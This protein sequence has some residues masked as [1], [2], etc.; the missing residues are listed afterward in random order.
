[1]IVAQDVVDDSGRILLTAGKKL[2]AEMI[3][4]L[5]KYSL[6][7]V[8]IED[9]GV[10]LDEEI[11]RTGSLVNK[12]VRSKLLDCVSEAFFAGSSFPEVFMQLEEQVRQIV[13]DLS[14]RNNVLI[15]LEEMEWTGEYLFVHSAHVGL[16]SIAIG[17][18]MGLSKEELYLLGMGGMLH[19]LGKTKIEA[20]I[21]NKE[22]ALSFAEFKAIKEHAVLGYNLLRVDKGMD[23]R[24]M[25]MAL[26]HHERCNGSGYPWGILGAQI[27]PLAK[28]VAVADVYDALT[29]DRVYRTKM[30]SYEAI[31]IIQAGAGIQFDEEVLRAF[32]K[33]AIPYSIGEKVRLDNGLNGKVICL[34]RSDL[35]RPWV[36]TSMGRLNLLQDMQINIVGAAS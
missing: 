29:T 31:K 7:Q 10:V 14:M 26:Q 34:N 11:H 2:S 1:M 28:V 35:H 4:A 23:H 3:A 9:N 15:H 13:N 24:I 8:A 19:D 32:Q 12:N 18:A 30:P 17:M 20:E 5:A 27:H 25:L 33:V 16:F 6:T 36:E 21:L 22:T